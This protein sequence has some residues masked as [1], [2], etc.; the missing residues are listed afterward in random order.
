MECIEGLVCGDR[1]KCSDPSEQSQARGSKRKG[2]KCSV[3]MDCLEG[4]LC[5]ETGLCSDP[6]EQS[7]VQRDV[8]NYCATPHERCSGALG[9]GICNAYY[10]CSPLFMNMY[11]DIGKKCSSNEN[12]YGPGLECKN[13]VCDLNEK[14]K[15][16]IEE[17]IE[18][19]VEK[20][21][22]DKGIPISYRIEKIDKKDNMIYWILFILIII[23]V[24][25]LIFNRSCSKMKK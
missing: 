1:G 22:Q 8:T 24:L 3:D 19:Y 7:Q 21:K 17:Y 2:D 6:S 20:E 13:N 25:F 9:G 23:V 14:S 18:K 16:E 10:F 15:Q 5:S 4:L 12:C 11:Y